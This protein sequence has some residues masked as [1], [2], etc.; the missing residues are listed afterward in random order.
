MLNCASVL[1]KESYNLDLKLKED[2]PMKERNIKGSLLDT[3]IKFLSGKNN[4]IQKIL[5]YLSV[6]V[7]A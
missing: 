3:A 7:T 2:L 5:T 6:K 1:L 4:V